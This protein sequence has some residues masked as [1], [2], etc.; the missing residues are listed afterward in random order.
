M[1]NLRLLRL[2]LGGLLALNAG[3]AFAQ[4]DPPARV[5]RLSYMEGT[6]SFHTADQTEWAPATLNYPVVAGESFWTEPQARA[7]IQVGP[8]EF[9]LDESTALDIVAL[10]DAHTRLGLS[11]GTINLHLRAPAPGGVEVLTPQGTVTLTDAGSY[12]IEA[13]APVSGGASDRMSI[14]VLEGLAQVSG[15]R[16]AI[17]V[18]PGESAVLMGDPA[19][20]TLLEGNSTPFDDWALERER[21]QDVLAATHYVSPQMTGYQDLDDYGQW[22][23]DPSY[24]PVWYPAAAPADWEPYRYGHWA[25]VAPWGWTWIDDA[26]W[27]FTPFHYGR[28]AF[29][30]GRWGW[31]PGT[32]VPRPVYA[33]ALVAFIGGAG[34]GV[35]LAGA[36]MPAVG[37][38]PLAPHE[39]YHPY[40]HT[41]ITYVRNVNI[42]SVNRTVINKITVV[43]RTTEVN[44]FAN[45]RAVTVVP[46]AAFTRAAPIH[47]AVIEVPHDQL[48]HA[49][50]GAAVQHLRPTA[51]ARAGVAIPAAAEA[52]GP[53]A[54]ATVART[55]VHAEAVPP[56]HAEPHVPTAPGPA[57][58]NGTRAAYMPPQRPNNGRGPGPQ[59]GAPV[60]THTTPNVSTQRDDQQRGPQHGAPAPAAPGH[61]APPNMPAHRDDQHP[62]PNLAG[63]LVARP[64][65]P[66]AAPHQPAAPRA[67]AAVPPHQ[68]APPVEHPVQQTRLAPTPQ[69]WAR[70]PQP[71]QGA[72]QHAPPQGHPAPA[73]QHPQHAAPKPEDDHKHGN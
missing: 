44:H 21:R 58:H 48:V 72:P 27:G 71:A 28:W 11:Q 30:D 35:T 39:V 50:A 53:H 10:D 73:A 33:P 56:G 38:V 36:A 68:P 40:Y 9:R 12:H 17:D 52:R 70:G 45:Q 22:R 6:V 51:A 1:K 41:S 25:W 65:T 59:H 20:V 43:N 60:P 34:F 16:R 26:P 49:Q 13:G 62:A 29:I 63:P 4:A 2:A 64:V 57:F 3:A 32:A 15:P 5:G 18:Q 7:E 37:W 31:C 55:P 54:P 19:G 47:R 46:S 66:P 42:T 23:T 8:A 24:G 61:A 69:G 14:T 67:P